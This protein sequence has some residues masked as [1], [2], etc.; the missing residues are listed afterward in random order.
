MSSSALTGTWTWSVSGRNGRLEE[1]KLTLTVTANGITGTLK[2]RTGTYLITD[3]A[4]GEG[5]IEFAVERETLNGSR[6]LGYVLET[7]ESASRIIVE[8]PRSSARTKA[9]GPKRT[10]T[11]PVTREVENSSPS[12]N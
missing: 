3:V 5:Q 4:I 8:I 9:D 2:D 10:E 12:G 1:T 11:F 6:K 7:T